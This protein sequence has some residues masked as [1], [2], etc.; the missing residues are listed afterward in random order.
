MK[1]PVE[2]QFVAGNAVDEGS[3]NKEF[4]GWFVGQFIP[5]EAG[6]RHT[7]GVEVKWGIHSAG[8]EKLRAKTNQ[9][10][11]TLTI[12]IS[13]SFLVKFPTLGAEVRLV[14]PGDYVLSKP[15]TDYKWYAL[16]QSVVL[17][18]RWPSIPI[19]KWPSSES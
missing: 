7:D 9:A 13:G 15:D 6:L 18:V 3:V 2:N 10:S 14:R 16:S 5:I 19:G 12:L 1:Q 8:E 17:T 4:P 11:N